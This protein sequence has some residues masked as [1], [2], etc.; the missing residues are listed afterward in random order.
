MKSVDGFLMSL[1]ANLKNAAQYKFVDEYGHKCLL[2][3]LYC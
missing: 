1:K 2:R 3:N